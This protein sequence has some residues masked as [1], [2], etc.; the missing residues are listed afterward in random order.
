M[1]QYLYEEVS[2]KKVVTVHFE[3]FF[4]V[5]LKFVDARTSRSDFLQL[6]RYNFVFPTGARELRFSKWPQKYEKKSKNLGFF[7]PAQYIVGL[8]RNAKNKVLVPKP[9]VGPSFL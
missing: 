2:K 5:W 7:S 6:L 3:G 1:L 9:S 4:E 8:A